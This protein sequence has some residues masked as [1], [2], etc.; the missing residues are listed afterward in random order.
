MNLYEVLGVPRDADDD[1]IR[2][3]YRQIARATHPDRH[4]DTFLDEN[5]RATAAYEI[6]GDPARRAEYDRESRPA[7]SA[8]DL[9]T[10][11]VGSRFLSSVIPHAPAARRDGADLVVCIRE[12]DGHVS[13]TDPR[14]PSQ[15]LTIPTPRAHQMCSVA[16]MGAEGAGGGTR[17]DMYIIPLQGGEDGRKR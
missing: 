4:G 5:R 6:L 17:G 9:L 2:R 10:R 13:L 14:D 16:D 11:G 3:A 8:Q 12:E 7:R 15:T 1:E